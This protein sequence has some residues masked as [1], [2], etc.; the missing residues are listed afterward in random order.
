MTVLKTNPA[1]TD[2]TSL[3][4]VANLNKGSSKMTKPL[5]SLDT[6]VSRILLDDGMMV[7]RQLFLQYAEPFVDLNGPNRSELLRKEGYSLPLERI[8]WPL[9]EKK[10]EP[11]RV[12]A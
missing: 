12:A 10:L 3:E 8:I 4:N 7:N 11:Y 5:T 9:E 6:R 2:W 1:Q